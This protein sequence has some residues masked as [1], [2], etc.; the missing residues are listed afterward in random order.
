[1]LYSLGG[2]IIVIAQLSG[3]YGNINKP[4]PRAV[5]L[6]LRWFTATNPRQLLHTR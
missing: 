1:M 2:Y 4:R 5:T 6:G 3:I